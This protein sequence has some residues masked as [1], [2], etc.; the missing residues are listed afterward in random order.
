MWRDI[1][2]AW[3]AIVFVSFGVLEGIAISI[4]HMDTLSDT[5]WKWFNIIP[6]Q[7]VYNWTLPHIIAASIL[8]LIALILVVHLGLGL[9]R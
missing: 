5:I 8:L 9:W 6:G 3:L 2:F 1:W 4:N 7:S